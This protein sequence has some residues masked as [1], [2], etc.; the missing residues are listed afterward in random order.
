MAKNFPLSLLVSRNCLIYPSLAL[1]LAAGPL[2]AASVSWNTAQNG[3]WGT[4][5]N[6]TSNPALPGSAD[7]VVIGAVSSGLSAYTVSFSTTG[8]I[9]SLTLNNNFGVPTL[10][11]SG[12]S[13]VVDAGSSGTPLTMSSSLL[14][15]EAAGVL[16]L[17]AS[18]GSASSATAL[19]MS[20][21]AQIDVGGTLIS[22]K[23]GGGINNPNAGLSMGAAS[24]QSNQF[25]VQS[26]GYVRLGYS[27]V[28]NTTNNKTGATNTVLVNGGT[29]SVRAL[30]LGLRGDTNTLTLMNS[31]T[32]LERGSGATIGGGTNQNGVGELVIGGTNSS[33]VMTDGYATYS[34]NFRVGTTGS[35]STGSGQGTVTLKSGNLTV[36]NNMTLGGEG[37]VGD[38]N[39]TTGIMNVLGGIFNLDSDNA[40]VVTLGLS[41][42]S[43][44][45]LNISGGQVNMSRSQG[46]H[47]LRLA[48]NSTLANTGSATLNL[49]GGSLNVDQFQAQ[50]SRAY[51][52]F[53]GGT[54]TVKQATVSNGSTFVIGDGT[55]HAVLQLSGTNTHVF[56]NGLMIA[57]NSSLA[58]TGVT[59]ASASGAGSVD[60]GTTQG[61]LTMGSVNGAAGM[62]M[63]F[64]FTG[65]APTYGNALSSGNDVLRLTGGTPFT[66]AFTGSNEI[67]MYFNVT[68]VSAGQVFAGGLYADSGN[69]AAS[70]TGA[71]VSYYVKG[72]GNGSILYNGVNYYTLAQYNALLEGTLSTVAQ[73]ADFGSGTVNG[74]V[75]EVTF[76]V[77]PEPSTLALALPVSF[78]MLLLFRKRMG[79]SR[80]C[81]A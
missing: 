45:I 63:N 4:A 10:D 78:G 12:G 81:P 54:F 23:T 5:S 25:N 33:G 59:T 57:S 35:A 22:D 55:H 76:N 72:D 48:P 46:D 27:T 19:L 49:S 80:Q 38:G 40:R 3:S 24:G 1:A 69:F 41:G 65:T 13:L 52:N 73:S 58:G 6:W 7:D 26:G 39:T 8:T 42:N 50:T 51:I 2:K 56:S 44:G 64:E 47:V 43:V 16:T 34:S 62:D 9:K 61:I 77:V 28:G 53:S 11:L 66:T 70:I 68:S 15:V 14:N 37:V 18:D 21:N 67:K 31:G 79:K 75:S 30:Y 71:S 60:P 32:F 20:G 74:Y 17:R 29:L 36:N